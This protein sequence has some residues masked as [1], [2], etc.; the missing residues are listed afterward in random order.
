MKHAGFLDFIVPIMVGLLLHIPVYV[1][2]RHNQR[3][4]HPPKVWL[5]FLLCFVASPTCGLLYV[6]GVIPALMMLGGLIATM[7]LWLISENLAKNFVPLLFVILTFVP[8]VRAK[9]VK[10]AMTRGSLS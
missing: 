10:D 8:P 9:A 6:D 4:G 5:A 3:D 2:Y 7:S 1:K